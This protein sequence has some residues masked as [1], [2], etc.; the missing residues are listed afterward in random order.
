MRIV[1]KISKQFT[2]P[3]SSIMFPLE[4]GFNCVLTNGA[5]KA[6]DAKERSHRQ[7]REAL[8]GIETSSV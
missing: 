1:F 3:Q 4:T 5:L 8:S 2:A 7:A 6:A